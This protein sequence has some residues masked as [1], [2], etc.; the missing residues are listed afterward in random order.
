MIVVNTTVFSNLAAAD[1]LPLIEALFRRVL[2][3]SQVH[4]EIL[5]GRNPDRD[6]RIEPLP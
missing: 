6:P 4:D 1:R 2:V 5:I 3:P